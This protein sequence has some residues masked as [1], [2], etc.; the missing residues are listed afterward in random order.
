LILKKIGKIGATRSQIL[1]QK[2]TKFDFRWGCAPDPAVKFKRL[3]SVVAIVKFLSAD[4]ISLQ[5]A[6]SLFDLT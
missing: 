1:R 4:I 6:T 3:M 5:W 2:C